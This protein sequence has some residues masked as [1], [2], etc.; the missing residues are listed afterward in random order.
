MAEH[1]SAPGLK[2]LG[3]VPSLPVNK[4]KG[5]RFTIVRLMPCRDRSRFL[6]RCFATTAIQTGKH[7]DRKS[8]IQIHRPFKQHRAAAFIASFHDGTLA[9][10]NMEEYPPEVLERTGKSPHICR[11]LWAVWYCSLETSP[12]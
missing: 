6:V 5:S 10:S 8:G 2:Q 1:G 4:V 12:R 9:L 7:G 11:S 3:Y